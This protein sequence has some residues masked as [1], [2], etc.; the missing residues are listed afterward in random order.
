MKIH[1]EKSADHLTIT[2]IENDSFGRDEVSQDGKVIMTYNKENALTE[3]EIC[4]ASR[5]ENIVLSYCNI[6]IRSEETVSE[7]A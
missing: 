5:N 1:Y 4:E 3:I 2:L 6:P 7:V